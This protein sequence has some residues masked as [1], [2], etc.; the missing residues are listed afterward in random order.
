VHHIKATYDKITHALNEVLSE[1]PSIFKSE[2]RP[3]PKH[4]FTDI[5]VIALSLTAD[6]IG[7]NSENYL[8][9]SINSDYKNHFPN[10]LSRRQY[11]DRRKRLEN[12]INQLRAIISDKMKKA[13][14]SQDIYV[15]DSMPLRLCKYARRYSSTICKEDPKLIPKVSWCASQ[16]EWYYGFKLNLIC[17]GDGIIKTFKINDSTIHDIHYLDDIGE[18]FTGCRIVGDKGYISK[19]RKRDFLA[20][21]RIHIETPPKKNQKNAMPFIWG[22]VRKTI[23]VLFSQ[24]NAQFDIQ[25]NFAKTLKGYITRIY[26]KLCTITLLHYIN[27]NNGLPIGRLRYALK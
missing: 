26:S 22:K 7:V 4:R 20:Q 27:K 2:L 1:Q 16:D 25:R 23:E 10:L 17:T 19:G 15:I 5:D 12:K 8:F 21:H 24:I 6:F 14:M 9:A 13:R 18:E 3:G 11:N